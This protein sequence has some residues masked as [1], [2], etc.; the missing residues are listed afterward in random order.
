[1]PLS[2][3][4]SARDPC[5]EALQRTRVRLP[6]WFPLLRVTPP[7]LPCFLS[8]SSAVLSIIKPK[9]KT[10]Q[11]YW[12]KAASLASPSISIDLWPDLLWSCDC[13]IQRSHWLVKTPELMRDN[14]ITFEPICLRWC[15]SL[16]HSFHDSN[17]DFS[18]LRTTEGESVGVAL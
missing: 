6:A 11:T 12:H 1:M 8:H 4:S 9:K 15:F 17:R 18:R 13:A 10:A 14:V 7:L 16:T 5:A 3:V 2:S